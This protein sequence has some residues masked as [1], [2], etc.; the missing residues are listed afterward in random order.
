MQSW[1]LHQ[2]AYSKQCGSKKE[3]KKENREGEKEALPVRISGP[4]PDERTAL[5]LKDIHQGTD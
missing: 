2:P 5:V 3:R 1:L 4:V